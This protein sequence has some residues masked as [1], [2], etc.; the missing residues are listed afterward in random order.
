MN[1]KTFRTGL[2]FTTA[3]ILGLV[4]AAGV[5]VAAETSFNVSLSG[6]SGGDPDGA[7]RGTVTIDSETNQVSWEFSY[8]NIAEPTAMHIHA[9]AE[10]QSGG[11]VVPLTLDKDPDGKLVGLTS[12]PAEAVQAILASPSGHYVNIHNSE[13]RGG[14]IRGQLSN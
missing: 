3:G 9:G 4:L 5:G 7:G 14:A 6:G 10:G 12:A 13:Y 2:C 8:S 11:V 1:S